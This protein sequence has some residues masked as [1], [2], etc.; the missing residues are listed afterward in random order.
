[1]FNKIQT[2]SRMTIHGTVPY[3]PEH[4]KQRS[5]GNRQA[6]NTPTS[7]HQCSSPRSCPGWAELCRPR[8]MGKD[9]RGWPGAPGACK[10]P[11]AVAQRSE[12]V[13]PWRGSR[14]CCNTRHSWMDTHQ[15]PTHA[16]MYLIT[17][18]TRHFLLPCKRKVTY[19]TST[20]PAISPVHRQQRNG[21]LKNHTSSNSV[22]KTSSIVKGSLS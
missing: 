21:F 2:I 13:A 12:V 20:H 14:R 9:R 6:V 8:P 18:W 1:M 15:C 7:P 17:T 10:R 11:A 5:Y 19:N 4:N 3:K 22:F 16:H